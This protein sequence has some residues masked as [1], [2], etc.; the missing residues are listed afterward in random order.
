MRVPLCFALDTVCSGRPSA[1]PL[2]PYTALFRSR[3]R[4]AFA[5]VVRAGGFFEV[6]ASAPERG[7]RSSS[8]ATLCEAPAGRVGARP[9]G[10]SEEHTS[11]HPPPAHLEGRLPV[12]KRK[13][14]AF[15]S[16]P[17]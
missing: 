1:S 8:R 7:S 6:H 16:L 12:V 11:E 4:C 17:N 3:A 13:D 9:A 5:A 2:F 15:S 10:R 14:L